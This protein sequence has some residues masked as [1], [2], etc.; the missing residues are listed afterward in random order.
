ME[1]KNL[2]KDNFVNEFSVG[3]FTNG[4]NVVTITK[5]GSRYGVTIQ[6]PEGSITEKGNL[7]RGGVYKYL[8]GEDMPKE[9]GG[10]TLKAKKAEKVIE[11]E[12]TPEELYQLW[13]AQQIAKIE[14]LAEVLGEKMA[15]SAIKKITAQKSAKIKDFEQKLAK[16]ASYKQ[17]LEKAS[18]E[19]AVARKALATLL[20]AGDT[21]KARDAFDEWEKKAT[22]KN[23]AAQKLELI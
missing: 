7:R 20:K 15:E 5:D 13:E 23:N 16:R 1:A 3:Q 14:T 19:E 8:F 17:D 9:A 11:I 22:A 21:A 18:A 10:R 4:N 12:K 2:T 6:T